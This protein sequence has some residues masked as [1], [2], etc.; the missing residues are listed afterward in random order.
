MRTRARIPILEPTEMQPPAIC[1]YED[2]QGRYFKMHQLKCDKHLRDTQVNH[3]VV[4]RQKCL[5][6]GR[7]HRVYPKG[8]SNAHQSDRLK[9][10]SILFYILGMSYRGVEDMLE[11]L[12]NPL[13]HTTVYH[14]V[15]DAGAKVLTL[16]HA[17][18]HRTDG[19][20]S[21]VG[22]D[23]TYLQCRGDK[24]ALAVAVDAQTG[25][26]LDIEI[27]ENE[28]TETL[29]EWLHPL[30]EL[31]GAE[32]LVTDDQDSFKTLADEAGVSHQICR[33]HVTRNVLD[34]VAK[35]AERILS[36]PPP[37]PDNLD[38]TPEQ[39]LEDLALLEWIML[40]H[41]ENASKLL[42][43]LYDRYANARS[44]QKGRRASLWYRMRNHVLR[45]WNNWHRYTCFYIDEHELA[46]PET[47]NAT[48]RVIGW[49]I[50]ER[51][52]TM[53]GY[54]REESIL[55][56]GMLT[57]WLREEPNGRDMSLLFAS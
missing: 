9:G 20:V 57:A 44:P 21:V 14:N 12:G 54:K 51:Y 27:M 6:C 13:D 30:L 34:F 53:R 40:G 46:I 24:V 50:K 38:T 4:Y 47:N 37:V 55:N 29:K 7:T 49:T 39:L 8:V 48:E 17:W 16:R 15:Q 3:V 41:P 43:E 22:G 56:V 19:K 36:S 32:I 2:C 52:R 18:L 33:Q 5:S 31:V 45:L 10:I 35:T 26:T 11:A 1:P 23:L 42:A 28:E 25:V